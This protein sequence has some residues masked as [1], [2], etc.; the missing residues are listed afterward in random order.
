[1]IGILNSL[2]LA[3]KALPLVMPFG[4]LALQDPVKNIKLIENNQFFCRSDITL[5][6]KSEGKADELKSIP[7]TFR[8]E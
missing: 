3:V 7:I 6:I 4:E 8:Y 5:V 2:D 1:M